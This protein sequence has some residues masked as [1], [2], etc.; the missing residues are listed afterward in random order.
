MDQGR[1]YSLVDFQIDHC[2]KKEICHKYS[3]EMW[4]AL[5]D[6]R[7]AGCIMD[8][9]FVPKINERYGELQYTIV[10]CR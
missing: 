7:A 3:E 1:R 5:E 8:I 6:R 2:M 10:D 9:L 4:H